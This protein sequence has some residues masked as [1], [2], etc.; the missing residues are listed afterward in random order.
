MPRAPRVPEWTTTGRA[1]FQAVLGTS[2]VPSLLLCASSETVRVLA[3]NEA[4]DTFLGLPGVPLADLDL[5]CV[6]AADD[7]AALTLGAHDLLTGRLSDWQREA[8]LPGS[9]DRAGLTLTRLGS[10]VGL[11]V[12]V[13]QLLGRSDVTERPRVH[14]DPLRQAREAEH[15]AVRRRDA[16]E[17]AKDEFLTTVSHEL[18]TPLTSILGF[19]EVIRSSRHPD[20]SAA[21]MLER[22]RRNAHRLLELVDGMGVLAR[23]GST[24][25]S[26]DAPDVDL[27]DVVRRAV[28]RVSCAVG[29]RGQRLEVHV[30]EG[31]V[32]LAGHDADLTRAVVELLDNGA[33]FTPEGGSVTVS[34]SHTTSDC[35]LVVEDTGHGIPADEQHRVFE[36]FARTARSID[37]A[38]PGTGIG[39]AILREVV[40]AHGGTVEMTSGPRGTRFTV[41]LPLRRA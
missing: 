9:G 1:T 12:L 27:L 8:R 17:R 2:P 24:P 10:P 7:A 21:A 36:R 19:T 11:P 4:A 22:I 35:S 31:P 6:L 28:A 3:A 13:L 23:I 20:P 5:D 14:D 16:L 18:R 34:L 41:R 30:P 15:E 40:S 37:Q 33:K 38:V 39:L 32:V 26:S 29:N 25:V